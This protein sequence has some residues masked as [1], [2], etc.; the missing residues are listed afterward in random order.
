MH[1]SLNNDFELLKN[2]AIF[3]ACFFERE[4]HTILINSN[5][6]PITFILW[7]P[8]IQEFCNSQKSIATIKTLN[9]LH[10]LYN[11]STK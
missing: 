11:Q 2:D 3:D 9:L 8:R 4:H 7:N 10:F 5:I 1:F 6:G